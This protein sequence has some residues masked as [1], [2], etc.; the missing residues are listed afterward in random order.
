MDLHHVEIVVEAGGE[1]PL[2]DRLGQLR[3]AGGDHPHVDAATALLKHVQQGHL[4]PGRQPRDVVQ[5]EGAALGLLPQ[6]AGAA[7]VALAA[8]FVVSEERAG[9]FWLADGPAGDP[10]Q[11]RG[12]AAAAAMDLPGQEF[13][14][15][16]GLA[17]DQHGGV[18]RCAA[19]NQFQD[20]AHGLAGG[21]DVLGVDEGR[22]AALAAGAGRRR[23]DALQRAALELPLQGLGD[24]RP[25]RVPRHRFRQ[26]LDR[27]LRPLAGLVHPAGV[28]QEDDSQQRLDGGRAAHEFLAAAQRI[29]RRHQHV[30]AL[31][32]QQRQAFLV[33]ACQRHAQAILLQASGGK[34]PNGRLAV[35]DKDV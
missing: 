27:A 21:D 33:A 35:N 30:H 19:A 1:V 28:G 3:G 6:P 4:G 11:R 10:H 25:Q 2:L 29:H 15:A 23:R 20:L 9:E 7:A 16:A 26:V 8:G 13:L 22:G 12:G 17:A 32:L 31:L 24:R 5:E 18:G 34:L 14:S